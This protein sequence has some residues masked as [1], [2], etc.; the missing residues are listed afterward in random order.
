MIADTWALIWV[1]LLFLTSRWKKSTNFK[2][3][4][5]DGQM[6]GTMVNEVMNAW[7]E[8]EDL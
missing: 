4:S 6:V 8:K 2:E 7:E 3:E 1:S 5:I